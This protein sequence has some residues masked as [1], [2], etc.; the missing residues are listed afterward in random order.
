MCAQSSSSNRWQLLAW[1]AFAATA[2]LCCVVLPPYMIPGGI[3]QPYSGWTI[4]PWFQTAINNVAF[5]PT[6][7]LLLALGFLLG[8]VRPRFW[9][10]L[11]PLT[12]SLLPVLL[13]VDLVRFP[14]SHNL[15][16]FDCV[17]YIYIGWP[18][19]PGAF[20]GFLLKY[21]LHKKR[22]A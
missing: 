8:I 3:K 11:G 22:A 12:M 9:W 7:S 19:V 1:C 20:I 10:L 15:W 5:A 4:V 14:T 16:P 17:F 13:G 6:W 2:G 18:A 21:V